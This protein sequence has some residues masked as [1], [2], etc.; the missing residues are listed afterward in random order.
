MTTNDVNQSMNGAADDA[1]HEL[2]GLRIAMHTRAGIEQAKG[3]LM[4]LHGCDADAA[5]A[6]LVRESQ[7][8]HVRLHQVAEDVLDRLR[9]PG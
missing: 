4:A 1:V 9:K 8:R 6:M 7:H 2:A 5:F 3:A